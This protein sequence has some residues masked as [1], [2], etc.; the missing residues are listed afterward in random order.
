MFDTDQLG[1]D[2][3]LYDSIIATF[4]AMVFIHDIQVAIFTKNYSLL[5]LI[6]YIG[7]LL[8]FF[9]S[10]LLIIFCMKDN[11]NFKEAWETIGSFYFWLAVFTSCFFVVL[12]LWIY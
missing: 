9:P 5:I 2:N 11:R 7:N 1:K 8:A 12:P 3:D 6:S 4:F 10:I